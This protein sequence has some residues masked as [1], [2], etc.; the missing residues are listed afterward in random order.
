MDHNILPP[1]V[2]TCLTLCGSWERLLV[3]TATH[4]TGGREA[5]ESKGWIQPTRSDA[6]ELFY[7][8]RELWPLPGYTVNARFVWGVFHSA[9]P[10]RNQQA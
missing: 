4:P 7:T 10:S 2:G 6:P 1:L 5:W 3:Q 8:L 9:K